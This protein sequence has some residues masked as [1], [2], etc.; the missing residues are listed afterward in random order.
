VSKNLLPKNLDLPL[1][2][3][4]DLSYMITAAAWL[5]FWKAKTG[6]RF[7]TSAFVWGTV[8]PLRSIAAGRK[9][10][11]FKNWAEDER[12]LPLDREFSKSW[13]KVT[14]SDGFHGTRPAVTDIA[15]TFWRTKTDFLYPS[16]IRPGI[17]IDDF[18]NQFF[19]HLS[20]FPR[21]PGNTFNVKFVIPFVK[22]LLLPSGPQ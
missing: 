18:L 9:D 8:P 11:F 3:D 15:L 20:M 7:G 6:D 14:L 17:G 4:G 16:G 13:R 5:P 2:L 19:C 10:L 21:H 1:L 22:K 12:S